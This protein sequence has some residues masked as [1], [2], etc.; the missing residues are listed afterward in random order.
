MSSILVTAPHSLCF[1]DATHRD[2]DISA[3]LASHHL[4]NQLN[5]TNVKYFPSNHHRSEFDLNRESSRSTEY[6]QKI[7]DSLSDAALLID[8]HSFPRKWF[9]PDVDVVILDNPPNTWYAQDLYAIMKRNNISV[10]LIDGSEINDIIIE[11]RSANIPAIIIEYREVLP[12]KT[13]NQINDS[14]IEWVNLMFNKLRE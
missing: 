1:R 10:A 4:V 7:T 12:T 9:G 11:A 5:G 8:V 3:F 6:R 14:V 13:I 2:C